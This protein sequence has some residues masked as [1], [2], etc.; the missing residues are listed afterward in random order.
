[1]KEYVEY[2]PP[3]SV[4]GNNSSGRTS[5]DGRGRFGGPSVY[6]PDWGDT[7]K[8]KRVYKQSLYYTEVWSVGNLGISSWAELLEA[9]F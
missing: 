2:L 6:N 3:L 7:A 1:M 9:L 8:P 5:D 4:T